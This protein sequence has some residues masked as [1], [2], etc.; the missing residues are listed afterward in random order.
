MMSI[1]DELCQ[2]MHDPRT[3]D[4]RSTTDSSDRTISVRFAWPRINNLGTGKKR[5]PS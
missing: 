2:E 1:R 3:Q 4:I 5:T